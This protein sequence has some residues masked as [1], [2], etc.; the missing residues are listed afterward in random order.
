VV[1]TGLQRSL[2][3]KVAGEIDGFEKSVLAAQA[4]STWK[5]RSVL[6]SFT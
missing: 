5:D 2:M 3:S 1:D 4:R 6:P